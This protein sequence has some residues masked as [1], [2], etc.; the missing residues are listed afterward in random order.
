MSWDIFV[1]DLPRDAKTLEDIPQDFVPASIGE[2]STIIAKIK[3][4]VPSVDFSDPSL[5]I[6]DEDDW[7]IEVDIDDSEDCKGFA[8]HVHGGDAAVGVVAAI[9]E[10]L[11]LRALDSQSGDFFIAGPEAVE[12]FR[13][14][15]DYRDQVITRHGINA[16]DPNSNT[17]IQHNWMFKRQ[18]RIF[19]RLSIWLRNR[20]KK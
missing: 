6:I 1:Q 10:H 3:E 16:V 13:K 19:S 9:L 8:F 2:R 4:V 20:P 11:N 14:W 5:G 12:N 17:S 15:R 18:P 7:S